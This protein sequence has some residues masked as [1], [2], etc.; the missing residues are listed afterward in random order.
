MDRELFW[1]LQQAALISLMPK[2][3][4]PHP[5]SGP[6]HTGGRVPGCTSAPPLDMAEAGKEAE[7]LHRNC[8]V[9]AKRVNQKSDKAS[10]SQSTHQPSK[11]LLPA[12]LHVLKV[13][14]PPQRVPL[15]G[16]NKYMT[17]WGTFLIQTTTVPLS[18]L[19][20]SAS[21]SL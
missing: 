12:S 6:V 20:K 5:T 14:Q 19:G 18:L 2:Q 1:S 7:R 8:T 9:Q 13:L 15:T 11:V 17:L 21:K 16:T 3:H 10:N 4:P